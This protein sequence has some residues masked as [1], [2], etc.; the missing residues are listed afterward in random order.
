MLFLISLPET[1]AF[2]KVPYD[3][4]GWI[5]KNKELLNET[6]VALL[7]KSSNKVLASLFTNNTIAGSGELDSIEVLPSDLIVWWPG[8]CTG[9]FCFLWCVFCPRVFM[10]NSCFFSRLTYKRNNWQYSL[11]YGLGTIII[12]IYIKN[13]SSFMNLNWLYWL[14]V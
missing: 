4:S 2:P 7:Q 10:T 14:A 8:F 12:L 5:G 1:H 11:M 3:I 6:V 13:Q 9:P